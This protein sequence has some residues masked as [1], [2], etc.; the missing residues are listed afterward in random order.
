MGTGSDLER[1][2]SRC[3]RP[4]KAAT[5]DSLSGPPGVAGLAPPR[6]RR[7]GIPRCSLVEQVILTAREGT[8]LLCNIVHMPAVS[9][10]GFAEFEEQLDQLVQEISGF[11]GR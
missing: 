10:P 2:I 7:P 8:E 3:R 9:R 11:H 1:L 5:R 4:S 6:A